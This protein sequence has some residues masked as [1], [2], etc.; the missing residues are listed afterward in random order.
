M[1]HV[2]IGHTTSDCARVW[3]KGDASSSRCAVT[4]RPAPPRQPDAVTL[5][6]DAVTLLPEHDYTA[7]VVIRKLKSDQAYDVLAEFTPSGIPARGRVKA[8]A[9]LTAPNDAVS[10][11]F[12]LSSCN[13]SVVSINDFLSR[14][15]STAGASLAM[16]SLDI[17]SYRW[18]FPK[19]RF[20]QSVCRP[21]ATLLLGVIAKGIEKA[22][23]LKQTGSSYLRSPFLKVSAVFESQVIDLILPPK[24]AEDR[25]TA[26]PPAGVHD[27]KPSAETLA[28]EDELRVAYARLMARLFLAVGDHVETSFGA[29]A[30]VASMRDIPDKNVRR[31]VLTQV[32]GSFET[33]AV[34][35][36]ARRH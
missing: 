11:S 4:L 1:P 30:V 27:S 28:E 9:E 15:A 35:F 31:L 24:P 33:G 18:N 32:N 16:S 14:L 12:V 6:S 13:L 17:P 20:L 19:S 3:V 5:S 7:T 21:V 8:F 25:R 26:K 2:I 10:F 36:Q 22:T 23:G 34:L 29:T